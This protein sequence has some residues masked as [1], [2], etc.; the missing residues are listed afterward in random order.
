[1][2]SLWRLPDAS[3]ATAALTPM[4]WFFRQ[5]F[6]PW[7]ADPRLAS[8]LYAMTLMLAY[9]VLARALDRRGLY[10]RA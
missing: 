3:G 2:L 8:L 5:G 9:G 10:W 1:M 4:Q 7:F 6:E